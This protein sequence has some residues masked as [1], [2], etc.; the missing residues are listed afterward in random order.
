MTKSDAL[1]RI[2][3]QRDRRG[4]GNLKD[5]VRDCR[6]VCIIYQLIINQIMVSTHKLSSAL[7]VIT[8]SRYNTVE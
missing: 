3:A 6:M 2:E 7:N 5:E 8:Q 4:V 1:E